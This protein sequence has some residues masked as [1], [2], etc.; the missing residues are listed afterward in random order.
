MT[1]VIARGMTYPCSD[2]MV[3]RETPDT[4]PWRQLTRPKDV[5][6]YFDEVYTHVMSLKYVRMP[7]GKRSYCHAIVQGANTL[8]LVSLT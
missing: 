2:A 7:K 8:E 5:Q 3:D 4:E 6:E 1:L